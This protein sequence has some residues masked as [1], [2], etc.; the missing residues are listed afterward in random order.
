M[1]KINWKLP[2]TPEEVAKEKEKAFTR[3]V[4]AHLDAKAQ[5]KGYDNILSACTYADDP[6]VAEFQQEG[7]IYRAWRSEVWQYFHQVLNDVLAG[8][9]AEPTKEELLAE[10]SEVDIL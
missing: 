4:Q 3:A 10:L 5:E 9:R 6:T 7:Q 1:A 2:P 8:N